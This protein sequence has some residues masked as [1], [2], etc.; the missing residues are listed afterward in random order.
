MCS[1][2]GT[3]RAD[4]GCIEH[5]S[6]P[7]SCNPPTHNS[8]STRVAL[9]RKRL[10]DHDALE[11]SV[12]EHSLLVIDLEGAVAAHNKVLEELVEDLES[13]TLAM[14]RSQA[15]VASLQP[16]LKE[17]QKR[18]IHNNRNEAVIRSEQVKRQ[19]LA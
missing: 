9:A 3:L 6:V 12:R 1:R 7:C 18:M 13:A 10:D 14:N 19:R 15:G 16:E 11:R 4:W 2:R 8:V 5:S 17:L